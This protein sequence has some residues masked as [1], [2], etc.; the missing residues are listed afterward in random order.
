METQRDGRVLDVEQQ[1]D[2]RDELQL[3][4]SQIQLGYLHAD[5]TQDKRKVSTHIFT[6]RSVTVNST[7]RL[8]LV[9]VYWKRPSLPFISGIV[10]L[11][12]SS[13]TN[14]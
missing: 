4:V 10:M 5:D 8:Y 14:F 3:G 9:M 7:W 12:S 1:T 11:L 6:D 2:V 13:S